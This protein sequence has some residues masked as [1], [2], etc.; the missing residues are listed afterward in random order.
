M[1][2]DP[3]RNR[4]DHLQPSAVL[5][6]LALVLDLRSRTCTPPSVTDSATICEDAASARWKLPASVHWPYAGSRS[7]RV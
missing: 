1:D 4:A 2:H 5:R 3:V 6:L 7:T